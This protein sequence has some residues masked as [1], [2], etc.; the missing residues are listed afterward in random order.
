MNVPLIFDRQRNS[1]TTF[2]FDH[3][4]NITKILYKEPR[5]VIKKV[6]KVSDGGHN[7]LHVMRAGF[8]WSSS[9]QF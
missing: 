7:I 6:N 2:Q 3:V 9:N 4:L 5:Q 1:I 8:Y